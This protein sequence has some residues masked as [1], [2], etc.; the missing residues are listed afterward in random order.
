M[1]FFATI[2]DKNYL[3]KTL[4]LIES[5]KENIFILCQD[6]ESFNF[7]NNQKFS[8]KKIF[9]VQLNELKKITK[10]KNK[11]FN[12]THR[13][14]T[15]SLK[16]FFLNHIINLKKNIKKIIIVDS[17]VFFFNKNSN[18]IFQYLKNDITL[19]LHNFSEQNK[20]KIKFGIF[21][22]GIVG[23]RNNANGKKFIQ[24]WENKCFNDC[25]EKV[26]NLKYLDQKYLDNIPKRYGTIGIFDFNINLAPWNIEKYNLELKKNT[27]YVDNK[28]LLMFHFQN[29]V[30]LKK[31]TFYIALSE[32]AV[33]RDNYILKK[34]YIRYLVFLEN[35]LKK[36]K[37]IINKKNFFFSF[38]IHLRALIFSDSLNLNQLKLIK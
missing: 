4:T 23:F 33:S 1:N 36:T 25:P 13:E 37:N 9:A 21:N 16:P 20:H 24:W 17:D 12:R 7:L 22:A 14:F 10:L 34:L 30:Y 32:Y 28:K 3:F 15:C 38:K 31:N 27:F 6:I 29:L 19:S 26:T 8:K 35:N 2:T 5:L 18:D 11:S